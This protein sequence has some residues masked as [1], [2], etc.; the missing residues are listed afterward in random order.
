MDA[1]DALVP[2]GIALGLGFLV[3]LQRERAASGIAGVRTFPLITVLGAV[4][5]LLA[6][7]GLGEWIVFAGFLGITCLAVV[8]GVLGSPR[9][10]TPTETW[11]S[12]ELGIQPA[13]SRDPG[14]TTEV[15]MI[16]MYALGAFV[17]YGPRPI[18]VAL[19]GVV[20]ILLH[21]KSPL[22]VLTQRIGQEEFRAIMRFVFISLVILPVLPNQTY[23]PFGVLNP[24]KVWLMV[25]LIVAIGLAG[26]VAHRLMGARAGVVLAGVLGGLVSSTATTV[27]YARL[28]KLAASRG[29]PSNV[30]AAASEAAT[31]GIGG[32]TFVIVTATAV[33]TL[34]VILLFAIAA[35]AHA[36]IAAAPLAVFAAAAALLSFAL[37]FARRGD[38]LI[39]PPMENPAELRPAILFG[40]LFAIMLIATAA[41][42]QEFNTGGV[43][44][45]GGISGLVDLDAITLSTGH[46]VSANE[47]AASSAWRA[48]VIATTANLLFKF[49]VTA[50]LGTQSLT[51]RV[52]GCFALLAAAGVSLV[53]FW[54]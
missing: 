12:S 33:S 3:G 10:G 45:V 18:A 53:V 20:A 27:S 37:Y 49:L 11:G 52:G 7:A 15:A 40:A 22:H 28:T 26:Y 38:K 6:R 8:G 47:L 23:G 54:P 44:I 41:A 32:A 13:G 2:L 36:P 43:Y 29:A 25:V 46:M 5:A 34:R 14:L 35:P 39:V 1:A 30:T 4:T 31:D 16:L 42:K 50:I 51:L 19:G 17:V 24:F 9:G 21:L 48:I